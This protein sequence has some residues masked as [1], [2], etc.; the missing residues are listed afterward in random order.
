MLGALSS[1]ANKESLIEFRSRAG[2]WFR[3]MIHRPG[4]IGLRRRVPGVV[5]FHGFTGDRMESHWLFVK[6]SRALA[7]TGIASLRFDFYGSGE[8]EG[9]FRE[10]TLQGEVSDASTAVEFLRRQ[11]G[12][13]TKRIG[14]LG[15]SMGGAIAAR[16][17]ERVKARALVLWAALARPAELRA[18]AE[19]TTKPI[20]G[21][22]G[23]REYSGHEVSSQFL[24]NIEKVDPLK[25]IARFRRPTL[26]IHPEKD[27]FLSLSHP[28]DYFQAAGAAIKEKVIIPGADH[29]FTSV[30]WEREV[31]ARTVGWFRRHLLE[32]H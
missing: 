6:C 17:T 19:R 4:Q 23:L 26:I 10:V 5:F 11:P 1:L 21:A 7:E 3:G 12:I 25:T 14:L 20:P 32:Q 27:E 2:K 30:A 29:T 9:Q 18:L 28:E 13:D 22:N 16:I 31:I 24:D 15:L 8:S